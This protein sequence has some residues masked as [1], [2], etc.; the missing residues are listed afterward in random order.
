M[1]ANFGLVLPLWNYSSYEDNLFERAVGEI[2]INHLTIPVITGEQT[3]F[4][5]GGGYASPYFH[6]EGGWHFPPQSKLYATSGVRPRAARWCA[7]RDVLANLRDRLEKLGL[8]LFLRIDLP[9]VRGLVEHTPALRCHSAWGDELDSYGP[10]VCNPDFRELLLAALTDLARYEPAGFQLRNVQIEAVPLALE[11]PELGRL[12]L[13]GK[14]S[15]L[16]FCAACRQI[17]TMAGVDA[18]AAAESLRACSKRLASC[19]ADEVFTQA[20]QERGPA[21]S[22]YRTA[23][24]ADLRRWLDRLAES[25]TS[26]KMFCLY[27]G[28]GVGEMGTPEAVT[29]P[30]WISLACLNHWALSPAMHESAIALLRRVGGHQGLSLPAWDLHKPNADRLV[31]F[32]SQAAEVG[33]EYFDFEK[34]EESPVQVVTW[35]KQA[36]RYARRMEDG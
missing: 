18:D 6:T 29:G 28:D 19:S 35:L 30:N 21:P 8:D 4:R 34:L 14:F 12:L 2:G 5:L 33:V 10:C 36:V 22:A 1:S 3:Q 31:R 7:T 20:W 11:Q 24:K 25:H 15:D 27:E 16:C 9:A 26:H 32:V 23:R 13:A 17:A